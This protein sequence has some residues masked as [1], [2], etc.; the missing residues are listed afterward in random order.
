MKIMRLV[1]FMVAALLAAPV[2]AQGKAPEKPFD[3]MQVLREKLKGDKKLLVAA[4]M[5]LTESEAKAFWPIYEDYQKG[6]HKINDRLA[7]AVVAYS[8]EY[9]AKSL[10]DD[11]ARK[12]L[13]EALA[14]EEAE[15]KLKR[16]FVPRLAQVLPGLKV[17]RYMQIENKIRAIVKYEI[18]GEVPL[19][20]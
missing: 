1:L 18:A 9:N 3:T 10:T 15:T 5:A 16:S 19:V 13:D 4:N 12:L 11:K 7:T 20:R 6:L 2:F 17:A 8:R 14:V